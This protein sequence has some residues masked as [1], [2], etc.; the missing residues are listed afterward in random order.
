[1]LLLFSEV[2]ECGQVSDNETMDLVD[3]L[4]LRIFPV[5]GPCPGQQ[6]GSKIDLLNCDIL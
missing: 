4:P 3:G 5:G 6:F 2:D 1:M